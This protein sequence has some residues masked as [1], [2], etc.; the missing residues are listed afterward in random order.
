M[1]YREARRRRPKERKNSDMVIANVYFKTEPE[2]ER[3]EEVRA[4]AE[5]VANLLVPSFALRDGL[6]ASLELA[7]L[8]DSR[9]RV[10]HPI[11]VCI[12]EDSGQVI[13]EAEGL[14]EYGSG[15]NLTEAI[16]DLQH[17]LAELYFALEEQQDKLAAGLQQTW[18]ALR[19]K[20]CKR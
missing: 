8:R 9:L 16:A 5:L 11:T 20:V 12:S 10:Q 17:A 7:F 18:D 15:A 14:D 6:P 19:S 1:P 3:D 4:E 2:R 13:A